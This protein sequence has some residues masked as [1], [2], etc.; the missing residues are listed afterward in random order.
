[1]VGLIQ[2]L[3]DSQG[4][5]VEGKRRLVVFARHAVYGGE[6]QHRVDQPFVLMFLRFL[7]MNGVIARIFDGLQPAVDKPMSGG[8]IALLS[9]GI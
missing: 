7:F 4:A 5:R 1:M 9:Q 6:L 3:S 8:S 2:A